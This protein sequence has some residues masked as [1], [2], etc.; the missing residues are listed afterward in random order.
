MLFDAQVEDAAT[1]S[2]A[3][4]IMLFAA[5]PV[6]VAAVVLPTIPAVG[7]RIRD[8]P[9]AKVA[10]AVFV[11]SDAAIGWTPFG[12]AGIVTGHEKLP[13]IPDAHEAEGAGDPASVKAIVLLAANPVP[14]A[15]VMLPTIP[16]VGL[17]KRSAPTVNDAGALTVPFVATRVRTPLG[18]GGIVT[19]HEKLPVAPELQLEDAGT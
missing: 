18:T 10:V 1:P 17:S 2:N 15:V 5:K 14:V 7:L 12:T 19:E 9:T 8:V 4:V 16:P 6:P 13:S 3:K 11:P